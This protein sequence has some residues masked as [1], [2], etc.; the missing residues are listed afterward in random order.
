MPPSV[1]FT[2]EACN[3]TMSEVPP[4]QLLS[5]FGFARCSPALCRTN[6]CVQPLHWLFQTV[7]WIQNRLLHVATRSSRC[8]LPSSVVPIV[9][10]TFRTILMPHIYPG[11]RSSQCA[12]CMQPCT[13]CAGCQAP[14]S[15]R[16][17]KLVLSSL[18]LKLL[19]HHDRGSHAMLDRC[20][21]G[22]FQWRLGDVTKVGCFSAVC[23]K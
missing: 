7:V 2:I 22:P 17:F 12:P 18:E 19:L 3:S 13:L 9:S 11:K 1:G 21:C 15:K 5:P 23:S 4:L 8:V 16:T 20:L 6:P 10:L 14:P